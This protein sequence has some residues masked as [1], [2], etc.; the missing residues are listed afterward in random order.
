MSDH[1]DKTQNPDPNYWQSFEELYSDQNFLAE[2]SKEFKDGVSEAPDTDKMSALSRRKFLALLGASAAVAGTAC[3]DYYDRGEI[4]PYKNKPEEITLGKPNY[5]ASTCTGCSS[6]CG[7][8]IKTREGRPIK[9]DGNPDH[10]V[11]KGKICSFGQAGI[12]ALY[13]PDRIKTPLRRIGNRFEDSN[14]KQ[15]DDEIILSLSSIG[16]KEIA[17]ITNQI[18]SPTQNEVLKDFIKKYPSAKIYSLEQFNESIRNNAWQKCYSESEFPII[19]WNDAEVVVSLDADFLGSGSNRIENTRLFAERRDAMNKKFNRLYTIESNLSLTGMNADYRLMLKPDLQYAFVM[20]LIN[21]L[22]K[23]NVINSS[24]NASSY[25]LADLSSELG[26]SEKTLK[27]LVNDLAEKKGKTII[28]AGDHL[29]ENVHIA[30]N[31]LNEELG[32]SALYDSSQSK[33]TVRSLSS[34]KEF[35]SLVNKMNAGN[36]GAVIHFNSNPVYNLPADFNYADALYKVDEVV[37]FTEVTNESSYLSNHVLPIHNTLESW[38][39]AKIRMGFYSLQQPVI[40]PLF[41]TRQMESVLLTWING[42]NASYNDTI[43]HEYLMKNWESN[44]YSTL[45]TKIDFSP[46]WYGA[47]HDG[48]V[49]TN[50]SVKKFSLFNNN[51]LSELSGNIPVN[52]DE[53]TVQINESYTVK[54]GRFANNGWL[55][56]SPHPVSKVTWDNYAAI[57]PTTAKKLEVEKDDIIEIKVNDRALALPVFIQPGHANNS[58]TIETGFGR[59]NSGTVADGVGFNANTLYCSNGGLTPWIYAG[60]KIKRIEGNYNLVVAQAI[61]DFTEEDK[62]DLPEKRGIIREGTVEQYLK[63]PHFLGPEVDEILASV[64]PPVPYDGLKWGMSIDLNKCLGCS[65]CFT[66]CNVENNIPVVGKDQVDEGREMH[67]LRIDRYYSGTAEDPKISTQP[68]LCQHCDQAP[69]EN[70]C[71]VAATTHSKD[72]L[73]Q[74]VYNRCVGTRYCS[75]NCPYK[76]RRFNFFNFRDRFQDGYQESPVFALLHNPEVTIRSRG[77][78]EKCTFCIQRIADAKSDATREGKL[79]NGSDVTTACQDACVTNAIQFGDINDEKGEFYKYRHHELG[80]YVLEE[81]NVIPNVTYLAKLR[82]THSEEA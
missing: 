74:M 79:I 62:K 49:L 73:N 30:V 68:M 35:K 31:L 8:L 78:M 72:G 54:D 44:I 64:N 9:I 65:E 1:I 77:V 58:I 34:L 4:V 33:E 38:G 59:T 21:E 63:D 27:Y 12:M 5:Y 70:V 7:I 24:V 3:S 51:V 81:L 20:A 2:R 11:S 40:A 22:Q 82:N 47:L 66:A 55:Q 13:D 25:K 71:P 6:A 16:N 42:D 52:S 36:V 67:W 10:P 19:K 75:N 69:C 23:K 39:D 17:I 46:F 50:D 45:N 28:Y 53:I 14:W 76:V 61:Y 41:D 80:Y 56:E 43:Y 26:L 32:N 29:P 15:V 57:S 37:T 48:I 18:V 60:V